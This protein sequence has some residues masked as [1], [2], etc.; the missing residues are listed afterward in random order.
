MGSGCSGHAQDM[1]Q[2]GTH[3]SPGISFAMNLKTARMSRRKCYSILFCFY[4]TDKVWVTRW[5]GRSPF[6]QWM[7]FLGSTHF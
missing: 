4:G 7:D 2:H 5:T 6:S 1:V 3:S